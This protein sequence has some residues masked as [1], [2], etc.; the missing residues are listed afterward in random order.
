MH[1]FDRGQPELRGEL[2][3]LPKLY[4]V[5][6]SDRQASAISRKRGG[7]PQTANNQYFR[8]VAHAAVA[9]PLP[10]KSRANKANPASGSNIVLAA[11]KY[12]NEKKM[13]R[14]PI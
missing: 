13:V 4:M 2:P 6:P 7:S 5:T 3:K 1:H 12:Q 8:S 10:L 9:H 11:L 14:G